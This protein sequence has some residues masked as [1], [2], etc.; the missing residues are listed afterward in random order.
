MIFQIII[1]V[2]VIRDKRER[3]RREGGGGA[4]PQAQTRSGKFGSLD[5]ADSTSN[6]SGHLLSPPAL[7]DATWVVNVEQISPILVE[8]Q[9]RIKL[10]CWSRMAPLCMLDSNE[11]TREENTFSELVEVAFTQK[12]ILATI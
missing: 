6:S 9:D 1:N 11:T 2:V 7:N 12:K 8:K 10:T 4:L 3:E 5:D